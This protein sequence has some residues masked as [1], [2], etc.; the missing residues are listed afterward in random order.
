MLYLT[1]FFILMLALFWR[2]PCRFFV[3]SCILILRITLAEY[4]TITLDW[5]QSLKQF[6]INVSYHILVASLTLMALFSGASLLLG[7]LNKMCSF[8]HIKF[9]LWFIVNPFYTNKIC[10]SDGIYASVKQYLLLTIS[11]TAS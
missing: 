3:L 1:S 4:F 6:F 2:N 5:F 9:S 10:N 7:W 11:C 8:V